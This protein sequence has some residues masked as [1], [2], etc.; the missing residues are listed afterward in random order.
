VEEVS[1]LEDAIALGLAADKFLL[2]PLKLF[3]ISEIRRLVTVETVW[4]TLNALIWIQ[5]LPDACAEVKL[6]FYTCIL[7]RINY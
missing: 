2:V 6:L 5:D 4:N 3:C 7:Q 1:S